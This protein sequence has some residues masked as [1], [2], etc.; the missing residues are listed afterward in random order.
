MRFFFPLEVEHYL[1]TCKLELLTMHPF[2]YED[3]T[4]TENEWNMAVVAKAY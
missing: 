3:R 2:K 4:L 1:Q